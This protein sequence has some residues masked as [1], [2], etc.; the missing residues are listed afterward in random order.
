MHV[1]WMVSI[2]LVWWTILLVVW[3][4]WIRKMMK[5]RLRKKN[6][7][8]D[9]IKKFKS[10]KGI[11]SFVGIFINEKGHDRVTYCHIV[12]RIGHWHLAKLMRWIQ[13]VGNKG[14]VLQ[15]VI[16]DKRRRFRFTRS[17][18]TWRGKCYPDQ[19]KWRNFWQIKS[20]VK[21]GWHLWCSIY[22]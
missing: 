17:R 12:S 5:S 11:L 8:Y 2:C 3:T 22:V 21:K 13:S 1:I 9:L 20:G 14:L 18:I 7:N 4:N 10:A 15:L 16:L 6:P 19:W